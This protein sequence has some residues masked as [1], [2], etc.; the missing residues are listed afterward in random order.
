[1]VVDG[2]DETKILLNRFFSHVGYQVVS[3][4]NGAQAWKTVQ[5]YR[6]DL[7]IV[8]V[9]KTCAEG[10]EICRRIKEHESTNTIPILFASSSSDPDDKKQAFSVGAVDYL[11]KPLQADDCLARVKVQMQIIE[12]TERLACRTRELEDLTMVMGHEFVA[13]REAEKKAAFLAVVLGVMRDPLVV[14]RA[15]D[16]MI[17]D[18][19]KSAEEMFG[20]ERTTF[21]KMSVTEIVLD[22]T[23]QAWVQHAEDL[24]QCPGGQLFRTKICSENGT[25]MSVDVSSRY[26]ADEVEPYVVATLREIV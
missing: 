13:R 9:Q 15:R 19:N 8:D 24:K 10:L 18:V 23:E 7:V 21:L 12:L 3:A 20:F 1:M 26:V 14:V 2:S 5:V 17:I 22:Y 11:L 16:G 6:P 4:D 25:T